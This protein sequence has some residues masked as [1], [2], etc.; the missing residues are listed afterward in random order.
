MSSCDLPKTVKALRSYIGAY[1]VVS[2]VLEKCSQYISPLESLS[3]GKQSSDSVC[4]SPELVTVFKKSQ[5]HLKKCEPISLP[6]PNDKLWLTTDASI[7]GIG[8]TLTASNPNGTDPKLAS[9]FSAKLKKGH[10]HWLPCEIECL[11]IAS[12]I[13]HFRPLILESNHR[14]TVLTDSKP[15][16]QAYTKFMRGEFSTS[17]RM[18]AFLLAATQNNVSLSHIKGI[19]NSLSDFQ[20]RNSASCKHPAC[21]VC[22][23]IN[24][25]QSASVNSVSVSEIVNGTSRVPFSSHPAWLQVQ[26]NCPSIQLARNKV[27]AQ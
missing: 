8:A 26:L 17:S 24:S 19:N 5:Q 1:K 4:W 21:S 7:S 15:A 9:F 3:S 22:K 27:L 12:S 13:T 10:E 14:T 11:G 20:S 18:Q 2:R 16:V 25:S 6:S 23:F